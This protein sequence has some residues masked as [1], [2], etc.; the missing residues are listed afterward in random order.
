MTANVVDS[1]PTVGVLSCWNCRKTASTMAAVEPTQELSQPGPSFGHRAQAQ[2]SGKTYTKARGPRGLM[3]FCCH[4]IL[5]GVIAFAATSVNCNL[6]PHPFD[7]VVLSFACILYAWTF[8]WIGGDWL[9]VWLLAEKPRTDLDAY[10]LTL[11]ESRMELQIHVACSHQEPI[12]WTGPQHTNSNGDQSTTSHHQKWEM[13]THYEAI[14]FH[15]GACNDKSPHRVAT[16]GFNVCGLMAKE[17]FEWGDPVVAARHELA[18]KKAY[19]DN[20]HRDINCVVYASFNCP[21]IDKE[22]FLIKCGSG[23]SMRFYYWGWCMLSFLT[24]TVAFYNYWFEHT[25]GVVDLNVRKV[26]CAPQSGTSLDT[27]T[28]MPVI[29]AAESMIGNMGSFAIN[30]RRTRQLKNELFFNRNGWENL[31]AGLEVTTPKNILISYTKS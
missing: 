13:C 7:I 18:M 26:L 28:K 2:S 25:A 21:S 23:F 16:G 22:P 1:P 20:K 27:C 31:E 6:W 30:A 11:R 9:L 10:L 14:T 4:L 29:A 17:I 15:Y 3:Q 12:S 5:P 8:G 19:D 24:G